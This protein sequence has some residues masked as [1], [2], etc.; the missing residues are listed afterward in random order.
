MTATATPTPELHLPDLPEVPVTLVSTRRTVAPPFDHGETSVSDA[1]S[2]SSVAPALRTS[3]RAAS[4][5]GASEAPGAFDGRRCAIESFDRGQA[6]AVDERPATFGFR[7]LENEWLHIRSMPAA[8][9]EAKS[10]NLNRGCGSLSGG[11]GM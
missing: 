4:T 7:D 6:I 9:A 11:G 10:G 3:W 8:S 2:A 1:P 5:S